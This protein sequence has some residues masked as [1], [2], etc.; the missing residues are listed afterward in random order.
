VN[1]DIIFQFISMENNILIFEY[2]N[3]SWLHN[4]V[5]LGQNILYANFLEEFLIEVTL[6][7]QSTELSLLQGLLEDI[8]LNCVH[9]DQ[10]VNVYSFGLTN[11]VASILSLLVHC[12][13]PICIIKYHTVCSS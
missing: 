13:I 3:A 9:A 2:V 8:L 4:R 10:S 5:I 12:W 6:N 1:D 11:S 7:D